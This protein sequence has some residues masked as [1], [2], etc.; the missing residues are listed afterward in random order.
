MHLGTLLKKVADALMPPIDKC[1]C[2]DI[3][4]DVDGGLCPRCA[5]VLHVQNAGSTTAAGYPAYAAYHYDGAVAK[6][7]KRY[8]YSGQKWLSTMM[9]DILAERLEE[10]PDRRFDCICHVPLHKKRRHQR[11]YDQAEV[12]SNRLAEMTGIPFVPALRRVRNT[13][14]QTR[15]SAAQRR[16]NMQGAFES[17]MSV[18]GN[19]LLVDDVLT[20]G[21][22]G[23][24]MCEYANG[25]RRGQRVCAD[26]CKGAFDDGRRPQMHAVGD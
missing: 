22:T 3:E 7:V 18:R 20:T 5:K 17:V 9:A 26:V 1:V 6:L 10:M 25:V 4:K 23:V 2:C 19:V 24:R 8:K 13:K 11:G 21:A 16:T 15:L 14:T 12:L